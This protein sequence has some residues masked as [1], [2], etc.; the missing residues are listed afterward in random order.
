MNL[1]SFKGNSK[2]SIF[3]A[4][5]NN[6]NLEQMD[7]LIIDS[8][9]IDLEDLVWVSKILNHKVRRTLIL[10]NSMKEVTN[11]AKKRL[12]NLHFF[13]YHKTSRNWQEILTLKK[14]SKVVLNQLH[15]DDF[16]RVKITQNLQGI[17]LKITTLPWCPYVCMEDC[18]ELGQ[19]CKTTGAL[20]DLVKYWGKA[21]NFTLEVNKEIENGWGTEPK[22]GIQ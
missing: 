14:Y 13:I 19:N 12:Q 10:T 4:I 3:S 2:Q 11:F 21:L 8:S 7:F 22:S 5:N 6:T 18:N 17:A 20:V 16:G 15:F 1:K 9:N